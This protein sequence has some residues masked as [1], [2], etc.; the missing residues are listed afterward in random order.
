[1]K[2]NRFGN[3]RKFRLTA[4]AADAAAWIVL[5]IAVIR[6]EGSTIWKEIIIETGSKIVVIRI[7]CTEG[8]NMKLN[9]EKS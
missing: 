4:T 2:S 1:M 9:K 7:A 5:S 3:V 6:W 8:K